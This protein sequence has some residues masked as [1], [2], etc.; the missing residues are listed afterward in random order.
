M[1]VARGENLLF[2]DADGATA[3][4]S[5]RTVLVEVLIPR[6]RGKRTR[7]DCTRTERETRP[8]YT[9]WSYG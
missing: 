5:I 2:L 3:V 1:L 4:E 8:R 9:G 7:R 6:E